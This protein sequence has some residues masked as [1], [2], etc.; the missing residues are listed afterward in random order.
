MEDLILIKENKS[1]IQVF[2]DNGG[3]DMKISDSKPLSMIEVD[4]VIANIVNDSD[5]FGSDLD[6]EESE[7]ED[8]EDED[9][10][11]E[12]EEILLCVDDFDSYDESEDDNNSD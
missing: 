10:E 5:I 7:N 3:Y 11:E 2:K 6:D 1:Q 9:S 8:M 12:E 4:E